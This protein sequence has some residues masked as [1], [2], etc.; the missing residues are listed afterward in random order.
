VIDLTGG[1]FAPG[2]VDDEVRFDLDLS[3]GTGDA[4]TLQGGS[5]H[6]QLTLGGDGANLNAGDENAPDVA[7]EGV[8]VWTLA[9]Q[10]GNDELTAGGGSGTGPAWTGPVSFQ[11]A[12]GEDQLEGGTGSD[13]FDGGSAVDTVDYSSRSTNVWVTVGSG[14][15][16]GQLG[17]LD[18]VTASI[19]RILGGSGHDNLTG[20]ASPERLVGGAGNDTLIGGSGDDELRGDIGDDVLNG[21]ANDDLLVGGAGDDRENGEGFNDVFIQADQQPYHTQDSPKALPVGSTITSTLTISGAPSKTNNVDAWVDIEGAATS[22]LAISLETPSGVRDVL[23][24]RTSNGTSLTGTYFD[25]EAVTRISLAGSRDLAGRFH[26]QG[27]METFNN[28][29]ANGTWT[30][31]VTNLAGGTSG[32][33]AGWGLNLTYVTPGPDG[34]DVISGGAGV[35]D[36]VSYQGRNSDVTATMQG[37][38]DD[39]QAGEADDIGAGQGNIE[40]LYSGSGDDTIVATNG[41]NDLRGGSGDDSMQGLGGDDQIRAQ[42][43]NDSAFGGDGTDRIQGNTGTNVIDGG[44]GTDWVNYS[45][46]GAAVTANLSTGVGTSAVFTDTIASIENITGSNLADILTGTATNNVINAGGGNDS[47]AGLAGNDTLSG[48]GGV[49]M[50]DG[51]S[52]TDSCTGEVL[53]GCP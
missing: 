3:A 44:S 5:G 22:S 31:I 9:G 2:F 20:D 19:E 35:L 36:L 32:V 1:Q 6:D 10:S 47:L 53:I 40:D 21:G 18:N 14:I 51:G 41:P 26:P 46:S 16:D 4:V 52:G 50:I 17:E 38:A 48:Q 11:G 49:D 28:M 30:L 37:T 39:G 29:I 12:A 33:L 45:A 43:G 34:S 7:A 15:N 8:E 13:V 23:F 42:D 25:S 24:D 27:S